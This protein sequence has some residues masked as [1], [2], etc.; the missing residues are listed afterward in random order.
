MLKFYV[1]VEGH[2]EVGAVQNLVVRVSNNCGYF[3]PWSNPLRWPNLH[4]WESRSG[5][6]GI[7]NGINFINHCKIQFA[8]NPLFFGES[9][10][11][12]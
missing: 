1:L 10:I 2:G 11:I 5:R 4:Q 3:Y 7:L 12:A 6:G 9:H 8:L